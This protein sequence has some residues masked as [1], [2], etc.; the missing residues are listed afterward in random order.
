ML[1]T[2]L[3]AGQSAAPLRRLLRG[4]AAVL[5]KCYRTMGHGCGAILSLRGSI[6]SRERFPVPHAALGCRFVR[7]LQWHEIASN[8]AD[9]E[10]NRHREQ[11]RENALHPP[12]SPELDAPLTWPLRQTNT[13]ANPP[14]LTAPRLVSVLASDHRELAATRPRRIRSLPIRT[15]SS[16]RVF[17][18]DKEPKRLWHVYGGCSRPRQRSQRRASRI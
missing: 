12:I 7:S 5:V 3:D 6:R 18:A 15:E 8:A 4:H 2:E 9:R 13:S 17:F 11:N 10:C 14:G 1:S 16:R